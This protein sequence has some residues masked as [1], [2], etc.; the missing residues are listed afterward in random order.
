MR[1]ATALNIV[2]APISFSA[3]LTGSDQT[4]STTS[5]WNA[6]AA[7][8]LGGWNV[9]VS[10]TDFA[11]GGSETIPVSNFE[12]RMLDAN[13]VRTAG[14]PIL[15]TSTQTT[16]AALSGTPLKIVSADSGEG[17]GD[18]DLTPD[19]QLALAADMYVGTG[20]YTATVTVTI[21]SGP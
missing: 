19:F 18:Y 5:T 2:T 14:S 17:E 21:T 8:D 13:I 15:P 1:E 16:F 7:S 6:L 4:V 12:I 20:T 10:S 9:T 11:D 3:N